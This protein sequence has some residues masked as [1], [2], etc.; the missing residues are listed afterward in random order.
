MLSV[1]SGFEPHRPGFGSEP[2]KWRHLV[3]RYVEHY[4]NISLNGAG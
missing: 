1:L 3:E 2:E 4:N